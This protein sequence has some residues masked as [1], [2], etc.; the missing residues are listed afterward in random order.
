MLTQK[1][2]DFLKDL[3]KNNNRD[4]FQTNKTRY[5]V[6]L[7]KPFE[8]FV[9]QIIQE[10]RKV[11]ERVTVEPKKAIFRIHRDT[12][13]SKD[14]TPYKNNVGAI[15]SPKGKDEPGLYIHIEHGMLMLSGGAYFLEKEQLYKVRQQIMMH[16]E[17]FHDIINKVAFKEKFGTIQ[18]EKNKKLPVE[19]QEAAV[20]QPLLYN[21]QF[22]A[23]AELD[24][25]EVLREDAVGFVLEYYK[26]IKPLNDFLLEVS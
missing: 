10:I 20:Q 2:L 17:Q 11:D 13:F 22:Y 15:I 8:D 25:K 23:M 26:A 24:P 9:G 7:K 1:S 12:R 4:W 6:D 3:A 19:F 21:K 5:E 14:K 18:G 16:S